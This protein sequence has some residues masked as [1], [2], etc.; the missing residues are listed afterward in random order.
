MEI[1]TVMV[2]FIILEKWFVLFWMCDYSRSYMA[3]CKLISYKLTTAL[4]NCS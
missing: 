2:I 1:N 4:V 3:Y